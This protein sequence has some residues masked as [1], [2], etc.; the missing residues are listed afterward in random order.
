MGFS[1]RGER[2][3][4]GHAGNGLLVVFVNTG[5]EKRGGFGKN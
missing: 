2:K 4:A 1:R 5:G 3:E